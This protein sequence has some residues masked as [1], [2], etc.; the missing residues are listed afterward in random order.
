MAAQE[1]RD[2]QIKSPCRLYPHRG[3]RNVHIA[4]TEAR[5]VSE[6]HYSRQLAIAIDAALNRLSRRR[7]TLPREKAD[8]IT[9]K[10]L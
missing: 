9:L 1:T 10:P 2:H 8:R 4:A 3:D 5:Y 7:D 6:R